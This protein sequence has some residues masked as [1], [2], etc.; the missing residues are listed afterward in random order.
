MK[1]VAANRHE[2]WVS[3]VVVACGGL[4]QVIPIRFD[5]ALLLGGSM[6]AGLLC[7][8]N[9]FLARDEMGVLQLYLAGIWLIFLLILTPLTLYWLATIEE[10]AIK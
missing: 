8:I 10:F 1:V 7:A 9:A 6:T 2:L 5:G 3:I 4:L